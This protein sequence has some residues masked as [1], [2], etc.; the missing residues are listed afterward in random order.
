M[1]PKAYKKGGNK[2]AREKMMLAAYIGGICINFGG[3]GAIHALGEAIGGVYEYIRMAVP[4][5]R[6]HQTS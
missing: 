5:L 4:S 3:L 1:A 2:E 6:L